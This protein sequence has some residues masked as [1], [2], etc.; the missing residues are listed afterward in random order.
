MTTSS[1]RL[2]RCLLASYPPS[3]FSTRLP[4]FLPASSFSTR[5]PSSSPPTSFPTP[6]FLL[7]FPLHRFPTP[8]PAP[9]RFRHLYSPP[10]TFHSSPP[11][12]FAFHFLPA[13]WLSYPPNSFLPAFHLLTCRLS[14]A[15]YFLLAKQLPYVLV[16]V[17]NWPPPS[18]RDHQFPTPST[19]YPP[20]S[21]PTRL[22]FLPAF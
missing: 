19:S 9:L 1:L 8:L 18:I 14:Y 10:P 22:A 13:F 4:A 7:S 17:S 2:S 11:V 15:F 20:N 3:S 16:S 6:P 5:L 21:F 12:P